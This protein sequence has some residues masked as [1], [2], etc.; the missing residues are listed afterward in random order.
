MIQRFGREAI[1]KGSPSSLVD[2][3]LE[4]ME[5]GREY[6]KRKRTERKKKVQSYKDIGVSLGTRPESK[7]GRLKR[8]HKRLSL[9]Q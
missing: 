3:V 9:R 2:K 4:T 8:T 1:K 6:R 7:M 5:R